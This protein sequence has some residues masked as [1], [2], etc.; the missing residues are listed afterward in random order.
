[1]NVILGTMGEHNVRNALVALGVAHQMGVDLEKAALK[2][3]EFHGQRQQLIRCEKCLLI[4]DTYNASPDSMKASVHVLSS[5]EGVKG[6]KIA[7]LSDMLELGENEKNYH[8]EVVEYIAGE[9]VDE[10]VVFGALSEEILKGIQS[11]TDKIQ[12]T[13]VENREAMTQYLLQS[14]T[15]E[16]VVLLKASNGMKLSE[17]S[18]EIQKASGHTI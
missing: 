12:L 16:D 11:K 14:V 7:A 15:P 5:M 10:V 13:K 17:V 18:R 8:F 2:L 1:M 9:S 3:K 6:R 4:D